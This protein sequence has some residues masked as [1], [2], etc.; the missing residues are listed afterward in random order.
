[1]EK[2][3]VSEDSSKSASTMAKRGSR[4]MAAVAAFNGKSKEQPREAVAT[5]INVIAI[6]NA[7]ENLLVRVPILISQQSLTPD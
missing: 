5:K 2:R 1:M 7:F 3:K 4:V 6:E